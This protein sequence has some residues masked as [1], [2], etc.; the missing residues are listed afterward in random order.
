MKFPWNIIGFFGFRNVGTCLLGCQDGLVRVPPR[1]IVK[2]INGKMDS[3][4]IFELPGPGGTL[5]HNSR[6]TI[7]MSSG[8]SL[9]S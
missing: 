5:L 4:Q 7:C 6:D 2:R 9:P 8:K 1:R 3:K